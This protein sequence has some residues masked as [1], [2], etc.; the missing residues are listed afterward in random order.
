LHEIVQEEND[1]IDATY[2]GRWHYQHREGHQIEVEGIS[3]R[4]EYANHRARIASLE[5]VTERERIREELNTHKLHLEEMV[6]TR[7]IELN[8][9]KQLAESANR[10]KSVFLANMSHELRTPLNAILGFTQLMKR[11]NIAPENQKNLATINRAGQHLLALINDVLEISRIEAGRTLL[12]SEPFDLAEILTSVEEMIRFKADD[13]GLQFITEHASNLPAFVEGDG[14]HLKQVLINLLGNAVKYTEQGQLALRVSQRNGEIN[15]EVSDTGPGISEQDQARIFQ[16]FYQTQGGIAKG[17]GTGLGLAISQEY[18]KM[19]KGRLEV[20][21]QPGQGSTFML[22]LPLPAV[23]APALQAPARTIIG[24]EAG[25]E[26]IRILIVDD[27]EDNRELVMQLLEPTGF[28]L[29]T[30]NDGQQAIASFIEWQPQLIW[31]DMRM[32]VMDGYQATQQI[33]NLPGGDKVKIVALTASAFEEERQKI[34]ESGCDDMVRKP[35]EEAS[36]FSVMGT[37]LGLPY[38]YAEPAANKQTSSVQHLDLSVLSQAQ[39]AALKTAAEHLDFD[40]MRQMV[41]VLK[42]TH[43]KLAARMEEIVQGFRFDQIAA[44]CDKFQT[45]ANQETGGS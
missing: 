2:R 8:V 45:I 1:A 39:I 18:T 32:P 20:K 4:I 27:K 17:E 37:L 25:Q 24:L 21:S 9:A 5:D 12:Q 42:N 43:P 29:R 44:L 16:P 3:R 36:L 13:K 7:T 11:D 33:R 35:L 10:A 28:V 31:M 30:A 14:P 40:K 26:E 34:I 15:F 41:S 23:H 19:M 22:S 38:R 6:E